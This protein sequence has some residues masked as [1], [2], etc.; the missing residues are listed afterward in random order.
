MRGPYRSVLE[1]TRA[2]NL[3]LCL[4]HK[5]GGLVAPPFADVH[6]GEELVFL[7]RL[8]WLV[9]KLPRLQNG[10]HPKTGAKNHFQKLYFC[11][12]HGTPPETMHFA[13]YGCGG[14]GIRIDSQNPCIP[15]IIVR[16]SAQVYENPTLHMAPYHVL[17]MV[18]ENAT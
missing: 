7:R 13:L 9:P 6:I 14:G 16:C 17:Q 5:G 4:V 15:F 12:V 2:G 10:Y 8:Y 3:S 11:P 1:C 18:S